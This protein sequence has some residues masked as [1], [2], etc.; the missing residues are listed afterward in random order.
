MQAH[1]GEELHREAARAK[2][3]LGL[4]VLRRRPDGYHDLCTI[5]Q[6]VDLA[7][8]LRFFPSE[9]NQLSCSDSSLSTGPDNLVATAAA[10][11][12]SRVPTAVPAFHIYLEKHIPVGAGLGGGSADAAAALR[13]LNHLCGQPLGRGDLVNLAGQ[14]G[15]DIPFL[16]WG[17]TALAQGRG[18]VL[19][20]LEWE[21]EVYYVLVYPGVAVSTAWAYG[22]LKPGLTHLSP[23]LSFVYSLSGGRVAGTALFPVIEND[24]QELVERANPIVAEVRTHLSLAGA[25]LCSM[26]GSGSTVYGIFDD[27]A[28]ALRAH[29][30]LRA[31]GYRSFFCAPA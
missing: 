6:S 27:R 29:Q 18:E 11:F 28:V 22:Q 31:R 13:G 24:F 4:K 7:D 21:G 8:Q 1:A 10:L 23:Y 17:G 19:T 25:Q 30:A 26:S 14:L 3:N 5:M 16:L 12:R 15:S 20:P 2:I 9:Q